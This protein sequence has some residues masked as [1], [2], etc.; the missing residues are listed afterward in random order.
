[1]CNWNNTSLILIS[2]KEILLLS[3]L[4]YVTSGNILS[5]WTFCWH[6]TCTC[7]IWMVFIKNCLPKKC[8]KNRSKIECRTRKFLKLAASKRRIDRT[9]WF[10]KRVF[11]K[12]KSCFKN[13]FG[14]LD[15]RT[16]KSA[17]SQRSVDGLSW[18][19]HADDVIIFC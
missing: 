1:M 5:V 7:N 18:F 11:T 4:N 14:H 17:V 2:V 16:I 3:A 8:D 15:H 19:L 13:G 9:N 6:W 10:Q 12:V